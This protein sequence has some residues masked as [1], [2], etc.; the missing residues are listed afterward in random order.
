MP[1]LDDAVTYAYI[2]NNTTAGTISSV[3]VGLHVEHP[4]ISDLVFHLIS[5]DGTRVLLM[6]N[7][8][9]T[10]P[11]GCGSAYQMIA[12][13][14]PSYM[15]G[16]T[17]PLGGGWTNIFDT[18]QT[19]GILGIDYNCLSAATSALLVYHDGV[20]IFNSGQITGNGNVTMAGSGLLTLSG[21][22]TFGGVLTVS[23]GTLQVMTLS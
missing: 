19:N 5:P 15:G 21:S 17:N 18:G 20:Q 11:D 14:S 9:G 2:T 10:S 1:I 22:N 23:S 13:N 16:S 4:R 6:E 12:T 7:R 3:D 8:G